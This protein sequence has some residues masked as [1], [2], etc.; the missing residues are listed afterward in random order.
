MKYLSIF[1]A[2]V[3]PVLTLSAQ[4]PLGNNTAGYKK[5]GSDFLFSNTNGDVKISFCTPD[6]FRVRASWNRSF[7]A[8]EPW[9]V[10]QYNWAAV[11]VTATDNKAYVSLK[12]NRLELKVYKAPFRIDVYTAE[13]KLL[14][15]E[16]LRQAQG[17]R[18]HGKP[19]LT[20]NADTVRCTKQ[21][22]PNEHFFGFGERMDFIDQRSKKI[23]LN[24]GRGK[25]LPHV[26]GAYNI[27]EANYCPV[28]FFM[29][30]RGYGIFLHNAF[31]TEWDMGTESDEQY[32]FSAAGGEMDYYFF[33]GPSFASI[34]NN[35]TALTGR[36]P[37]MPLFALGLQVGTYA[38][39]TWGFEQL[40]SDRY[41]IELARK[42]RALGIPVDILHIDSVWRIFGEG[43]KGDRAV[44]S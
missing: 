7:E 2:L 15:S 35:Y 39:G 11:A 9:M 22:Q 32:S 10:V 40:T 12:T 17:D 24:V 6:L 41:V 13:G 14:S 43:G 25:G 4:E 26:I 18:H 37:L 19:G 1:L 36:P 33:Y 38:G 23:K 42:L 21:L 30:T 29:S 27:L 3:F 8:N 44:G 34:L 31:P 16:T 20:K 5:Q 28:P